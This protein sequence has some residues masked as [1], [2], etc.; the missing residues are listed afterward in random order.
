[1]RAAVA[2]SL[3]QR[4]RT[5]RLDAIGSLHTHPPADGPS[6][7]DATNGIDNHY[8]IVVATVSYLYIVNLDGTALYKMPRPGSPGM[9]DY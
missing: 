7:D 9:Y 4:E 8:Y 2:R 5:Q 6:G 1:M 3:R